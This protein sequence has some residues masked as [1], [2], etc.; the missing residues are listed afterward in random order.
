M[1]NKL[2]IKRVELPECRRWEALRYARCRREE[3][4]DPLFERAISEIS[5]I[6]ANTVVYRIVSV[7]I[8]CNNVVL[9]DLEVSSEKL[10]QV[11]DGCSYAVI[12]CATA[13]IGADRLIAKYSATS[14]SLAIYC[15]A[16]ASER[17]EALS[18]AFEDAILCD[19]GADAELRPRFSPGYGDLPL[20]FQKDIFRALR[21]EKYIGLTL[22]DSLMMSPSKSVSAI[23][24]VR[25]KV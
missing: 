21:P 18:D 3:N 20:D 13:G 8:K 10:S 23:I 15:D 5:A 4:G 22:N 7:N 25:K 14:P 1:I 19:L 24:G 12:F 6:A 2:L 9:G 16:V 17:V 11:L